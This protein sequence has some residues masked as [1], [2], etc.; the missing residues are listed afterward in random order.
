MTVSEELPSAKNEEHESPLELHWLQALSL[1][2]DD[3]YTFIQDVIHKDL[4][5][6]NF[7]LLFKKK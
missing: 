3:G 5:K 1:W 2:S 6:W 4:Q 7:I